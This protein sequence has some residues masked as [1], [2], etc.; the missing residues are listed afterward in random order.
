MNGGEFSLASGVSLLGV[1][2]LLAA[3][4]AVVGFEYRR[5]QRRG[6]PFRVILTGL[7]VACLTLILTALLQPV[8]VHSVPDDRETS[9]LVLL[10]ISRSMR[11]PGVAE[12][13]S[14]ADWMRQTLY[15]EGGLLQQLSARF[16][17]RL[18]T[19]AD[20]TSRVWQAEQLAPDGPRT[21]LAEAVEHSAADLGGLPLAGVLVVSDGAHNGDRDPA[22]SV[23]RLLDSGVRVHALSVV[24]EAQQRDLR[25]DDVVA[26]NQVQSGDVV[27]VRVDLSSQGYEQIETPVRL[28]SPSGPAAHE[29]AFLTGQTRRSVHLSF[30]AGAPGLQRYEVEVPPREDEIV[31]HNNQRPFVVD[32]APREEVHVLFLEGR[33]RAEFAYLRRALEGE[34]GIVVHAVVA[35]DDDSEYRIGLPADA[36]LEIA[37]YD[38]I[39]LGDVAVARHLD[40]GEE[41]LAHY[42]SNRGG[43]L[44][45]LGSPSLTE[46]GATL[47][48]IL[49]V[50]LSPPPPPQ[51]EGVR[52]RLPDRSHADASVLAPE[53]LA[54]LPLFRSYLQV[55][56]AKAAAS[57]QLQAEESGDIL[58]ASHRYGAGRVA[59]FGLVAS[60]HWRAFSEPDDLTYDDFWQRT[61]RG[62]VK[63]ESRLR[64]H[65]ERFT[66]HLG[67][68][69]GLTAELV[70]ADHQPV[71]EARVSVAMGPLGAAGEGRVIELEPALGEPGHY[72]GTLE[73]ETAGEYQL[74]AWA[75]QEGTR[76]GDGRGFFEVRDLDPELSGRIADVPLLRRLARHGGGLF[77][78]P[79]EVDEIAERLTLSS[80]ETSRHLVDDLWDTPWLFVGILGLLSG[81]WLL[82][83]RR[84]LVVL[85][86]AAAWQA[87][88]AAAQEAPV[89]RDGDQLRFAYVE[90]ETTGWSW[91]RDWQYYGGNNVRRF[92]IQL[93]R[94]TTVR[95]HPTPE[96]VSLRDEHRDRLFAYPL[97]FITSNNPAKLSDAEKSNLREYL[98]RGG[99]LFAD[100]CVKEGTFNRSKPPIFTRS[101]IEL[102]REVFPEHEFEQIPHDHPIY[103]CAY[104]FPDGL[105]QMH[106]KGR[107]EGLGLFREGRLMV[108]LSP[109]DFCCGLQFNWGQ[110]SR[111]AYKFGVNV[112]VYALTH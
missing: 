84:G 35:L 95:V 7:R 18:Y 75:R 37:G 36:P 59:F 97:L 70:D 26:P 55:G 105:P 102:F 20:G 67:E 43:G 19:F 33:P 30:V 90:H 42:V 112:I 4:L 39:V 93:A 87:M 25:I 72:E 76:L 47:R 77:F 60:W 29:T 54:G 80:P 22:R 71:P 74:D 85:A 12:G 99:F 1:A 53:S 96:S 2:V 58:M 88:P 16:R 94:Q 38:A 31:H 78:S 40:G 107:W 92:L 8:R 15:A 14:R 13:E 51:A 110:L 41:A 69:V 82:R 81:E 34:E 57:V 101:T 10:D 17:P 62:L 79:A 91:G 9:L 61:I 28:H 32:V 108:L 49:P 11:L 3:T 44:L 64:L 24:D 46:A 100:D 106:E 21:D 86:L 98:L 50:F 56:Q 89:L 103:H 52:L 48:D 111:N 63:R 27:S 83:R 73:P 5:V 66:Y 68:P 104:E 23:Q 65:L 45:V 109:N 6:L